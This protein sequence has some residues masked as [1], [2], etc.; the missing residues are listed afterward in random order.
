MTREPVAPN[1]VEFF[2]DFM[3]PT[4]YLAHT[5]LPALVERTGARIV[6]RP[7]LT[8]MLQELVGNRSPMTVKNKARWMMGE[9][10]RFSKRYGV[11]FTMNPNFPMKMLDVLHGAYVALELECIEP[12]SD[13]VYRACWVDGVNVDDR[14]ALRAV[15]EVAKLDADA[16]M[17]RLDDPSLEGRL[18]ATTQEAADRGAFGS[19]TF[20]VADEMHFGQ[21]RLDFV[22]E[23]L[24]P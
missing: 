5:Q 20:F 16:I 22:E 3:S 17:G 19:P 9:L 2:F 10:D 13:A 4:A 24:N 6:R 11:P 15:L 1:T 8:V 14:D 21:D 12:Y 18:M 23:A 7:M